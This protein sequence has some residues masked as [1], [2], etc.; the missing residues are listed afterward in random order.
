MNRDE[1]E[2]I[3]RG[4]WAMDGAATLGEAAGMLRKYA[5]WLEHLETEGFKL[6]HPVEDDY[7]FV[8]APEQQSSSG[9]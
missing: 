3:I 7:G 5:D 8:C 4:K 6:D 2:F 1:E 9:R